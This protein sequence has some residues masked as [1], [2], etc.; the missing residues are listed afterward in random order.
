MSLPEDTLDE[1]AETLYN[2][3]VNSDPVPPISDE[4]ELTTAD[5]YDVQ[6]GVVDR[7]LGDDGAIAGH[8]LGLVSEAKQEQLGI[9]EPIF[10]YVPDDTILEGPMIPTEELIAPRLEAEIGLILGEDLEPPVSPTDVLVATRAVV[11]V[12]EIL[13][14]RFQGWTIPSAQDVIADQTSAG[15]VFVGESLRDV[16]DVDLAMESVVISVNGEVEETGT[17]ADIMGHPARAVAWLA[18]RL[19]DRDDRLEAGELV[20]TG[21]INAAIDIEPGDVYHAKFGS[22]GDIELRAE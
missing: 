17:G 20:M 1:F 7:L 15:R 21:G 11:P 10:G 19:E 12:I 22:I 9:D 2:A 18:N 16:T 14:S 8:K 13:E 4:E 3:Q 5:A 6:A